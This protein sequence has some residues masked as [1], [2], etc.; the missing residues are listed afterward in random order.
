MRAFRA[1]A[2]Q[3]SL[4]SVNKTPAKQILP[5]V[6]ATAFFLIAAI[7][8][9]TGMQPTSSSFGAEDVKSAASTAIPA[10]QHMVLVMEENRS[11]STVVGDTSAWPNLNKLIGKG[12]LATHYYANTHPSIG[13][14]FMLTTGK[15]LTNNDASTVVWNVDNIARRMIAA[16]VSFR[17]YAEGVPR[18]YLGGNTGA[19]VLRHNPFARL[20]DIADSSSEAKAHLWPFTQ[21]ATDVANG[22]LQQFS[23]IVPD[24][25]HD[26]HNGTSEEADS[27]LQT[28][29]VD[30]LSVRPAFRSGGTGVLIVDF[31]EAADSDTTHGGGHIAVVL[32]GP[33]VK[34][35]Y[36]QQSSTVYQHPSMLRTMM[37]ALR[38]SSP[39]A[40]AA[41][42]P[43]MSEFFK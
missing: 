7:S 23:F 11:Y 36:R 13:N 20:S 18:G 21:F 3:T 1:S 27:W 31:D 38:L 29:V 10:S 2:N 30:R 5:P 17:I 39:P 28:N 33:N 42:A 35:G 34:P 24:I 40:A 16:K 25:Y 9:G 12:A 37:V 32:W 41:S 26:A 15:I 8:C 4:A 14:Y 22:S 19:Y 43:E 6:V